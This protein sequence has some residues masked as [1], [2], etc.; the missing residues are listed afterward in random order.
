MGKLILI[1]LGIAFVWWLLRYIRSLPMRGE[2]PDAV[3]PEDMVRC[4]HCGVYLPRTESH[5]ENG[6]YYCSE[7][8]S[9]L[10]R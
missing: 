10:R 7:E 2:P 9:R 6:S 4:E 3:T 8:H 1:G 5:A